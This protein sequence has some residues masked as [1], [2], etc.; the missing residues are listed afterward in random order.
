[1]TDDGVEH[2]H[3][4]LIN[5]LITLCEGSQFDQIESA[6]LL[7]TSANILMHRYIDAEPHVKYRLA[8]KISEIVVDGFENDVQKPTSGAV[9]LAIY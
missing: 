8:S 4:E 7:A 6:A 3:E 1:M 2:K 9:R 5:Q